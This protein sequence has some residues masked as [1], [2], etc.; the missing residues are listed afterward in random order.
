MTEFND[1]PEPPYGAPPPAR[2]IEPPGAEDSDIPEAA[3]LP[4]LDTTHL[5]RLRAALRS[6][7]PGDASHTAAVSTILGALLDAELASRIP[8]PDPAI[9]ERRRLAA[10][11]EPVV[12]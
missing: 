12:A 9:E 11:T 10:D 8:E 6:H 7:I 3:L 4:S 2:A 1:D 5:K